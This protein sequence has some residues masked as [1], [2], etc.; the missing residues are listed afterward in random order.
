[1]WSAR[2][3][4]QRPSQVEVA[5]AKQVSQVRERAHIG[6]KNR[7]VEHPKMSE[8]ASVESS[9]CPLGGGASSSGAPHSQM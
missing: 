4:S 8:R 1:M 5:S 3:G 6:R 7:E 9:R 2:F